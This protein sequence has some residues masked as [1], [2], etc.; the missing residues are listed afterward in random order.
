MPNSFST[1]SLTGSVWVSVHLGSKSYI[2]KGAGAQSTYHIKHAHRTWRHVTYWAATMKGTEFRQ[3]SFQVPS[4]MRH[5]LRQAHRQTH[6][7]FPKLARRVKN[8]LGVV[9]GQCKKLTLSYTVT[10][11]FLPFN[12]SL[13]IVF[14]WHLFVTLISPLEKKKKNKPHKRAHQ[15]LFIQQTFKVLFFLESITI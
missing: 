15:F 9:K 13:M 5:T 6:T 3:Y 7:A 12:T 2:G 8:E 10:N 1:M 4:S 11:C 14:L